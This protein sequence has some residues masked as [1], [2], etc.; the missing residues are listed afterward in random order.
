[1]KYLISFIVD[2]G[3]VIAL[4]FV[5]FEI[6]FFITGLWFIALLPAV[7]SLFWWVRR[8]RSYANLLPYPATK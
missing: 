7:S 2:T 8:G 5:G 4:A 3:I 1:M 6:V